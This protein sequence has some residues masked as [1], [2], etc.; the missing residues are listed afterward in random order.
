MSNT[1][2]QP[3]EV[4][5]N[6]DS[7]AGNPT[8]LFLG[9]IGLIVVAI[10]GFVLAINI[11]HDQLTLHLMTTL[12]TIFA[13]GLLARGFSLRNLPKRIVVGPTELEITTNKSTTSY[14]WSEIG[15]ATT[16]N[17]LNSHKT[18]L[19]ISDATGKTITRID[20]SFP[21]YERLVKMVQ[22]FVD[23]KPDDIATRLMSKK[24]KRTAALCFVMGSLFVVGAVFFA[25][26][27]RKT[28]R[29][30]ALL[31]V[32]GVPG[33]AELVRRI[34]APN[35]R[36]K[37]VEYR[38]AG[39]AVK[40]VEVNP[41]YWDQLEGAK[42]VP[43]IYVP[44]EPDINRLQAGEIKE[45]GFES[46]PQ[47]GYIMSGVSCLISLFLLGYSPLAWMGYDLAFDDKTRIWKVKR[48]GRVVWASKKEVL[49]EAQTPPDSSPLDSQ[50][51]WA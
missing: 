24:M 39:S 17:V 16:T 21:E 50:D 5:E 4:F 8:Y 31:P 43:V 28:A 51:A 42:T 1:L 45:D 46:T 20:E 27:A 18:C 19:Q 36:T 41:H 3:D 11:R 15:S 29:V 40:N 2:E 47:G 14:P 10:A 44:D 9:G 48:Y 49:V 25:L 38:I 7:Q 32:K 26:E 33:E 22:S 12:P 30:N 35:G 37:R 6:F 23:A 13:V 34:T